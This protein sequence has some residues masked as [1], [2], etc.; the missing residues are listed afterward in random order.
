MSS[1]MKKYFH[2]HVYPLT[3]FAALQACT[4]TS[5]SGCLAAGVS[6]MEPAK[7]TNIV[8]GG[9]IH[10][11]DKTCTA[12][13]ELVSIDAQEI[14]LRGYSA[15]HC[16]FET[17]SANSKTAISLYFDKTKSRRSGYIKNIPA[18]EDFTSRAQS[19]L[20]EVSQ[21]NI[22]K[23]REMFSEALQ[24][25]VHLD[26]WSETSFSGK[27]SIVCQNKDIAP[28]LI[29]AAKDVSQSCWTFLDLGLFDLKINKSSLP[30]A[31]FAFISEQLKGKQAAL[32][33]AL[34]KDRLLANERQT[35]TFDIANSLALLRARQAAP[36]GYLLNFD[37]C[38]VSAAGNANT[39]Q[40]CANQ[41]KLIEI[42]GRYF[43]EDDGSGGK[44]N[45]FD[46]LAKYGSGNSTG[47]SGL[48]FSK[49]QSG[50]RLPLEGATL[51]F[52]SLLELAS[53]FAA[54][55]HVEYKNYAAVTA[56]KIRSSV[57]TLSAPS[58]SEQVSPALVVGTN[59]VSI[60]PSGQKEMRFVQLP[61]NSISSNRNSFILGSKSTDPKMNP[62]YGITGYG[63]LRY[64]LPRS[65]E[66][67]RF[68]PTDSG[69]M[70]SIGGLIP[71]LTL[72]TVNDEPTSGGASILALPEAS[73]EPLLSGSVKSGSTTADGANQIGA[74]TIS[75]TT[76][77]GCF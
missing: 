36:L 60:L 31:D 74:K 38:K 63:I 49:L 40:L 66:L 56:I 13:F 18:S 14:A 48:N 22:P 23:A 77:A 15:R 30:E 1:F 8:Q 50:E 16:R 27:D 39:P 12:N 9:Y 64:G 68:Q 34:S 17:A 52:E 58:P 73:S 7:T 19:A 35:L 33:A 67:V 57:Q 44:I 54:D 62:A 42:A 21:L 59:L 3:F 45:I 24:V 65:S 28:D 41:K 11:G 29:T 37:L 72:N 61:M 4:Q 26:P 69:S 25:P 32:K 71:I 20:N 2:L 5:S 76:A 53:G 46:R 6:T 55:V 47:M 43:V 51:N 75:V 10:F 70:I